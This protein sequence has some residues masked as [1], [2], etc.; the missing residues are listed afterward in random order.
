MAPFSVTARQLLLVGQA[1][2]NTSWSEPVERLVQVAPSFAVTKK[3]AADDS[4]AK[5]SLL[6]GQV[7]LAKACMAE[8]RF[9]QVAPPFVLARMVPAP[10]WEPTARQSLL[11]GQ[12]MP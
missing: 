3:L 9:C 7:M 11:V 6:V 1:K 2:P 5:Q 8:A 10:A 12:A 4:P